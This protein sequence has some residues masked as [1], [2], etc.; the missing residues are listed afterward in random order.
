MD[1]LSQKILRKYPRTGFY[2]SKA[3]IL[4]N[5]LCNNNL[6]GGDCYGQSYCD[7][8]KEGCDH[9]NIKCRS[10]QLI[11]CGCCYR[12][13]P[14]CECDPKGKECYQCGHYVDDVEHW[15]CEN[16]GMT[17]CKTCYTECPFCEKYN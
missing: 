11:V 1:E 6:F 14:L 5:K 13:C 4:G 17:I 9:E 2:N 7:L 16:C 15:D 8:D 3:V 10:C 12:D